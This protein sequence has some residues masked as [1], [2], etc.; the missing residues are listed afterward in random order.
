MIQTWMDDMA[1]VDLALS[2]L[3]VRQ[4]D[5][6]QLL[7]VAGEAGRAGREPDRQ[8]RTSATIARAAQAGPG[9]SIMDALVEAAKTP[10]PA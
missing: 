1:G 2:T 8:A 10:P 4:S 3:R 7:F 5:L 6:V 9:P